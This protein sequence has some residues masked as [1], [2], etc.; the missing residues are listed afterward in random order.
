MATEAAIR[1]RIRNYLYGVFPTEAPFVSRITASY[2]S[3][4]TSITVLEDDYWE[5]NDVLENTLTSEQF[6]VTAKPGANVLT[7]IP[8]W[9]GTTQAASS[10]TTD[11]VLKNPRFSA[12]AIN[13]SITT[14]ISYLEL[15]GIHIHGNGTITR[16]DPREFYELTETDI[17]DDIGVY[18][19]YEVEENTEQPRALPFRYQFSLG[20]APLEYTTTGHGVHILDWGTR[21]NGEDVF[22]LYAKKIDAT[23]DLLTR[24]E[25]LVVVGAVAQLLG[26]TIVPATH[27][28]G[29]RT[30]RTVA[31]GQTSRDVR[32]F[33]ARFVTEARIEEA[34]LAV[35][36]SHSVHEPARYARARR[37]VG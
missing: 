28:P 30:D 2:G 21:T 29:A 16:V 13:T 9:N 37:W 26:G 32:Y 1:Q 15:W 22:F 11:P 19:V 12:A 3:G 34:K 36:R 27:D 7:V 14:C 18:K 5:V 31:P 4:A 20:I 33:Q 6:L 23:T 8:G 24:Q 25:E 10:G 35:E 17:V